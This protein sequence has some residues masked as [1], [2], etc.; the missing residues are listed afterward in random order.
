ML[1]STRNTRPLPVQPGDGRTYIRSDLPA[2]ITEEERQLLLSGNVRE[3]VDLREPEELRRK[4]CPLAEDARFHYVNMLVTGGSAVPASPETVAASYLAMVD[5][6]MARILDHI[7]SAPTGVMFFCQA[8]KDRTGMVAALLLRRMGADRRCIV[9]DYVRSGAE[10]RELLAQY[11]AAHP[12]VSLET[13][14][15]RAETMLEVLDCLEKA[16]KE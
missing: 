3:I 10:L 9:D 2:E 11:A 12:S 8:G 5:A 7:E 14:T 6:Q 13:I 4:P 16:E 1:S 15:P